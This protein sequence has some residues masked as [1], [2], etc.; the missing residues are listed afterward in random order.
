MDG[1][2]IKKRWLDKI[3]SYEKNIE[4][5]GQKTK[6]KGQRIYLLSNGIV[7]GTAVICDCFEL[8]KQT[9]EYYRVRH[10]VGWSYDDIKMIYPNVYAWFL[11]DVQRIEPKYY[12]HPRGA[13]IW[14]KDVKPLIF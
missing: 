12:K 6:K 4:I 7:W 14:V 11:T 1:L 9:Y 10:K 8:S 2:I 5:R 13:V 3:L